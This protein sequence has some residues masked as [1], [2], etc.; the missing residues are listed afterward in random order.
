MEKPLLNK[1]V[2]ILDKYTVQLFVK[3][4]KYT[5]F[6][7]VVDDHSNLYFLKLSK[8][9]EEEYKSIAQQEVEI[10][11]YINHKNLPIYKD[12]GYLTID[13][14][15]HYY[16]LLKYISG[17]TLS[18][19][20]AR[21]YVVR[22]YLLKEY[23]LKVLEALGYLHNLP[24]PIIH[25]NI[26]NK[27]LMLDHS[28]SPVEILLIGFSNA[29][30]FHQSINDYR[31]E[32]L[33]PFYVAPE[34]YDK[35]YSPQSDI[36]SVGV[37]LYHCLFGI[38]PWFVDLSDED[39]KTDRWKKILFEKRKQSLKLPN[40]QHSDEEHLL[41]IISTATQEDPD[42]RFKSAGELK[43]ALS[44][45]SYRSSEISTQFQTGRSSDVANELTSKMKGNGFSDIAGMDDLKKILYDDVIRALL[46]KDLYE[47]YKVSIPNGILLYGPPGCGKTF[48][49][50]KLA[51]EVN[52]N[53][54]KV[55]P[56]DLASIYI[57]GTQ[58]KIGNLFKEAKEKAPT[59]IFIDELD[60]FLPVR[61]GDVNHSYSSEVNE[62]LA[63]MNNCSEN[64]I[65]IISATN[66]PEKI[67]PAI[68]RT[69]RID[70]YFYVPPPDLE[71]R[72]ALFKLYLAGRPL[73]GDINYDKLANL[74]E[75][76]V[77]SD[78][79]YLVNEAAR[80]ALIK[81]INITQEILESV[82]SDS[83]P[84]LSLEELESYESIRRN[85]EN[86]KTSKDK[87]IGFRLE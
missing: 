83:S 53:F 2:M 55:I 44:E 62:F 80:K 14:R 1:N 36:Y 72:I 67:D 65:F 78:I 11:Q 46:Q 81:K 3:R 34:C 4:G 21:E 77:T 42:E 43:A 16:I 26:T 25:N 63:Q 76:Y 20:M 87:I 12:S 85:I 48:F 50:E 73:S 24:D 7:R 41:H 10:L 38:P 5:E 31:F 79:A 39:I 51:E 58:A 49:A 56:S 13:N 32:G 47:K 27:N 8:E 30:R 37:L 57:H 23:V 52:F 29:T 86:Q 61:S 22:S 70:K 40:I 66:R 64:G 33:N 6:Y 60:A 71:A 28:R 15:E 68:L 84:S 45:L 18:E 82:I 59:I 54:I 17:E 35:V 9:L 74:T 69:G 19:Y 75:N